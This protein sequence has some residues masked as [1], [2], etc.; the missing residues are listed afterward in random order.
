MSA[1]RGRRPSTRFEAES[2]FRNIRH[3][4]PP[5]PASGQRGARLASR[6][7]VLVAFIL[8]VSASAAP[9]GNLLTNET[10]RVKS[11]FWLQTI[12][13]APTVANPVA[14]AFDE[15]DRLWVA[16]QSE[17][18]RGRIRLLED[19]DEEG[20]Y[21]ADTIIAEN[22]P[23]PTSLVC[24]RGGVYVSATPDIIY[25]KPGTQGA[26]NGVRQVVFSGFSA[27]NLATAGGG[28]LHSL[29]WG[30]DNRIYGGTAGLSGDITQPGADPVR[31]ERA[32]FSFDPRSNRIEPETGTAGSGL[33]FDFW[34]NRYVSD[35]DRPLRRPMYEYRHVLLNPCVAWPDP[36]E[37]ILGPPA[38]VFRLANAPDGPSAA[39]MPT[40]A[41]RAQRQS[42]QPAW[43]ADARGLVF[44]SGSL[45]PAEYRGQAFVVDPSLMVVHRV[46]LK[47][48]GLQLTASRS[49]DDSKSEFLSSVEEGFR[50]VYIDNGPD[51]ALYLADGGTAPGQG[52]IIRI[53]P[54]TLKPAGRPQLGKAT[55]REL[56]T[57]LAS[58]NGWNRETAA[59]L[60]VE[61]QDA[62]TVPLLTNM[63]GGARA[64]LARLHALGVLAGLGALTEAHILQALK[65]REA[66]VRHHAL[67][68]LESPPP[69]GLSPALNNL[70]RSLAA[71][72]SPLVRKQLALVLARLR[73]PAKP[74]LLADILARGPVDPWLSR[75]VLAAAGEQGA[76]LFAG[77]A[78]NPRFRGDPAGQRFLTDLATM[79][80]TAGRPEEVDPMIE[81]LSR[82]SI[83]RPLVF[84]WIQSLGQGLRN[85]GGSLADPRTRLQPLYNTALE[86]AINGDLTPAV[87]AQAIRMLGV[88]PASLAEVGDWLFALA[89]P[90]E[91]LAVQL[92][93]ID[94]LCGFNDARIPTELLARWPQYA[95]AVRAQAATAL[96]SRTERAGPMLLG[97]ESGRP[98]ATDFAPHQLNL[99]RS[100]PNR[101]V[102]QRARQL[103]GPPA[104]QRQLVLEQFQPALKLNGSVN[105]GR[106]I[107]A[108]RCASCHTDGTGQSVPL[109]HTKARSRERV[110]TDIL[111]PS[112]HMAGE[113]MT[114][115]LVTR[116]G[117]LGVGTLESSNPETLVLRA[118]D[119]SL[120]VFPRAH[121]E[122][123]G[124]QD[125]SLMPAGLEQGLTGQAIADVISFLRE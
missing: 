26:T 44:Y 57:A 27:T 120:A 121:I 98:A 1:L 105:S 125:W 56:V 39:A 93:C 33:A 83:D 114:C 14:F 20:A 36:I 79:L 102:S 15:S 51:G 108:Q 80:G 32:D 117:E 106:Q 115:V 112:R 4:S 87:R 76:V 47:E 22:V 61:R 60:L 96:L 95:P 12:A 69:G 10:I 37:D 29:R 90:T 53:A 6:A 28:V 99:L 71:D 17:Q 58:P 65:D 63:L 109:G 104:T 40:K 18:G 89:V 54:A 100:H 73:H 86:A 62:S 31:I 88:S 123:M 9:P 30:L 68:L 3:G 45:F 97:I 52:R 41:N 113:W 49:G 111:D 16:E 64:P 107:F 5:N 101:Q 7:A 13:A 84:A 46:I 92:A 124:I 23:N 21:R 122:M 94:V 66:N 67:K 24:F 34:G 70:L 116:G 43:M 38:Q 48:N 81:F 35:P 110:F 78:S 25:L 59:R 103:L 75:I 42:T 82:T 85:A 55:I 91:P 119:G 72:P 8:G 77:T 19:P 50:P 11:G 2:R 118:P 74:A